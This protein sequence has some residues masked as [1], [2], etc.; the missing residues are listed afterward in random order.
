V[1]GLLLDAVRAVVRAVATRLL[2]W[3]A[4]PPVPAPL[5]LVSDQA[6]VEAAFA[7]G[8]KHLIRQAGDAS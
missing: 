4:P 3:A 7:R 5:R 8:S 2:D 1:I 6:K